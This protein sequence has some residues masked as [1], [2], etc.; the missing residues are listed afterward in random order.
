ML[1]IDQTYSSMENKKVL[2]TEGAGFIGNH[3]IYRML[4][5]GYLVNILKNFSTGKKRNIS[6]HGRVN[7]FNGDICNLQ[8]VEKA[9]YDTNK[10]F[11]AFNFRPCIPLI[12]GLKICFK[13]NRKFVS[14]NQQK[15]RLCQKK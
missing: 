15:T 3:A 14:F 1:L 7:L 12:E 10:L 6:T 2:V 4:K 5:A 9:A 13:K 11:A 8:F